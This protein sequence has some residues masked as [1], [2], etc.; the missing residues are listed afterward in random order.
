MFTIFWYFLIVELV[1][2]GWVF[3]SLQLKRSIIISHKLIYT[4]HMSSWTIRKS[5]NFRK[6]QIFVELLSSVQSFSQIKN[7]ASSSKNLLKNRIWTFH[8]ACLIKVPYVSITPEYAWICLN[9]PQYAWK[10]LNKLFR[11]CQGTQYTAM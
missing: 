9:V 10:C 3:P 6:S 11:L 8:V 5:K 4:S 2:F 7:F 1:N